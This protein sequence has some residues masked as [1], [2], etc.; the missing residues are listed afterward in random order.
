[1]GVVQALL[2]VAQYLQSTLYPNRYWNAVGVACCIAQG[3]GLHVDHA[4]GSRNALRNALE[5]EM[6]RRVWHACVMMD[7]F[8]YVIR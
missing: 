1:M 5:L 6:Q 8:V 4:E 3:L 2:M 7:M